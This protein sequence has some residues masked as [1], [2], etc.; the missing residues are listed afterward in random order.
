MIDFAVLQKNLDIKQYPFLS[1]NSINQRLLSYDIFLNSLVN[2][3][4]ND[5]M[6]IFQSD[7][8][9]KEK[10]IFIKT[11]SY[12]AKD[13]WYFSKYTLKHLEI[14]KDSDIH[15]II[16]NY[17]RKTIDIIKKESYPK[18]YINNYVI[19]EII[20]L[21]FIKENN[22]EYIFEEYKKE[23]DPSLKIFV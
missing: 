3:V 1:L 9:S 14:R 10:N 5:P 17:Y 21:I 11:E 7:Y 20:M 8:L 15:D 13:K 18:K 6:L 16:L 19:F 2:V 4:K 12:F 22:K 23:I